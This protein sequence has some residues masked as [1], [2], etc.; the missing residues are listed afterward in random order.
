M[1]VKWSFAEFF[2]N[3][4]FLLGSF[5]QEF[6]NFTG[7]VKIRSKDQ[8]WRINKKPDFIFDSGGWLFD[9]SSFDS[10][11]SSGQGKGKDP[12]IKNKLILQI[13]KSKNGV[14]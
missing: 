10:K 3:L 14:L 2:A 12:K 13:R 1:V 8:N 4:G 6:H 11:Q 7:I 9:C 5:D